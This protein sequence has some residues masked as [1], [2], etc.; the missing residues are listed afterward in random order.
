MRKLKQLK[1][2]HSFLKRKAGHLEN[3]L[4]DGIKSLR[5]QVEDVKMDLK[6]WDYLVKLSDTGEK[7]NSIYTSPLM[8]EDTLGEFYKV[9]SYDIPYTDQFDQLS[10]Q[11]DVLK[12]HLPVNVGDEEDTFVEDMQ[13]YFGM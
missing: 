7:T 2:E 13:K 8:D 9:V 5:A 10:H 6:N 11:L 12:G 3:E 1:K 4:L